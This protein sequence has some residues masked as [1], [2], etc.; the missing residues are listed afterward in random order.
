MIM[1]SFRNSS[2]YAICNTTNCLPYPFGTQKW[3]I[4]N[5]LCN[6]D[7]V[8]FVDININACDGNKFNCADGTWYV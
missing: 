8:K 7:K 6:E 5:D 3:Y 1:I 4:F 2:I